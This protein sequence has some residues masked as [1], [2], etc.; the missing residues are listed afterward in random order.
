MPGALLCNHKK[1]G[2]P[3]GQEG[4]ELN[5][6]IAKNADRFVALVEAD[7]RYVNSGW[8]AQAVQGPQIRQLEAADNNCGNCD[9]P[10]FSLE[11]LAAHPSRPTVRKAHTADRSVAP[12]TPRLVAPRGSRS[13][14]RRQLS[15]PKVPTLKFLMQ[16]V[17]NVY[18]SDFHYGFKS[19]RDLR[20][21]RPDWLGDQWLGRGSSVG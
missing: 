15:P 17:D 9:C 11:K 21:S 1:P 12:T 16:P 6:C 20:E 3:A 14:R 8:A 2:C 7:R 18:G 4:Q 19:R 5:C 10:D 13:R